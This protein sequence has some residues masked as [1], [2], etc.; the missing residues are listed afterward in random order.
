MNNIDLG[1]CGCATP[2]IFEVVSF[3]FPPGEAAS[4][5][6]KVRF[7]KRLTGAWWGLSLVV[8]ADLSMLGVPVIS[9]V[10]TYT[11]TCIVATGN[12]SISSLPAFRQVA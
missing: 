4:P 3:A 1:L 7:P 2:R 12:S 5:S 8:P 9:Y 10:H 11:C 6:S